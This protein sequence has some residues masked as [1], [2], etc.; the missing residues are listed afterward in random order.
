MVIVTP[1]SWLAGLVKPTFRGGYEVK[2]IHNGVD[3][4]VFRPTGKRPAR[5]L[6]HRREYA[7]ARRV[8]YW[9]RGGPCDVL[10][11]AERQGDEA[12]VALSAV[13]KAIGSRSERN[14][15]AARHRKRRDLA[16]W[17]SAADVFVN[18]TLEDTFPTTQIERSPA[19]R[20]ECFETGGARFAGLSSA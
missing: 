11:S 16:L 3:R 2:T 5:A 4:G 8:D 1:S 14:R 19:E 13:E 20:R 7:R 17:Y 6:R 12:V 9:S 18:P 15:A 10:R